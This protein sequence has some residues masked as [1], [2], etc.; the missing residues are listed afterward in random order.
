MVIIT[1]SSQCI[2][3]AITDPVTRPLPATGLCWQRTKKTPTNYWYICPP[4]AW[5]MRSSVVR[6]QADILHEQWHSYVPWSRVRHQ[7]ELVPSPAATDRVPRLLLILADIG[8]CSDISV[9]FL[10]NLPFTV[11][12]HGKQKIRHQ[13]CVY[14][15]VI[16]LK[17]YR[18]Y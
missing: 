5:F 7:L 16:F 8:S 13:F 18:T 6:V 2:L 4:G 10:S 9:C 15:V 12:Q 11:T 1:Q 14:F 3:W 17:K